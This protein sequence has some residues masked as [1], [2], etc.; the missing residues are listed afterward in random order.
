MRRLPLVLAAAGLAAAAAVPATAQSGKPAPSCGHQLPDKAGDVQQANMDFTGGFFQR[1]DVTTINLVVKNLDKTIPE[2]NTFVS[3]NLYWTGGDDVNRFVRAV[4]DF[5]GVVSYEFGTVED[6]G[7]V[8]VSRAGGIM[9]GAMFEGPDGV[10]QLEIPENFDGKAG[11]VLKG[12]NAIT[13]TGAP[14]AAAAPTPTRG[15]LTQLDTST[16]KNYTIGQPCSTAP[17][18]PPTVPGP[19]PSSPPTAAAPADQ[20]L[21]VKVLT[22]RAKAGKRV[23]VKLRSSEP[24]TKLSAQLVRGRKAVGKG[25]LARLSGKGTLKLKL[26]GAKRGSYRLDLAGTDSKGVRR[27]GSA[28][29]T[30]R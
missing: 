12:P 16:G 26:R 22:R 13:Y 3:W 1:T 15:P 21:P 18:P 23:A 29:L 10:V 8:T 27:F 7:S 30:L 6:G 17:T 9:P 25:S 24:L 14:G 11:S 20:K 2:G 4:T 28:K 5:S 19:P